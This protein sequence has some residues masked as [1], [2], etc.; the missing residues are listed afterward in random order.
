ME[1]LADALG[2]GLGVPVQAFDPWPLVDASGL[3]PE[4]ADALASFGA[5][6]VVA[7]GL[8]T[9]ATDKDAYGLEILP[10]EL[11]RKREF[12]GRKV[13]LIAAA[14]LAVAYLG[15][16]VQ[17]ATSE[18]ADL[19]TTER[20]LRSQVSRKQRTDSSTRDLLA[21]NEALSSDAL[22]LQRI[23]GTGEQMAR[24][25]E[26]L[27]DEMPPDFWITR[28]EGRWGVD[29]ELRIGDNV[30]RPLVLIKGAL[31]QGALAPIG[32][33]QA[34]VE[35]LGAALPSVQLNASFDRERYSID[36]TTFGD[37][38]PP[39]PESNEGEDL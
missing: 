27:G 28:M 37:P 31:R 4:E 1:G 11:A 36:L 7:L 10:P 16:F 19:Q 23:V 32:Q 24:A 8:A 38:P 5:E 30:P 6:A 35:G 18:A 9:M 34:L 2:G 12:F 22:D 25:L 14:V 21:V 20:G 13:W 15:L 33:Y 3:S 39:K 17:Q 26:F 29:K